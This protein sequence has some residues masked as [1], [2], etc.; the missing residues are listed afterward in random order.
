MHPFLFLLDYQMPFL[1]T[2]KKKKK[3]IKSVFGLFFILIYIYIY[4]YFL[5][6]RVISN[7]DLFIQFL[8]FRLTLK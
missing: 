6:V 7:L 2:K 1:K 4:I 5:L 8:Y 3:S